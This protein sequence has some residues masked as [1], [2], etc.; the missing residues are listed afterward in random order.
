MIEE[1]ERNCDLRNLMKDKNAVKNQWKKVW[2]NR[3]EESERDS[4][5]KKL[6]KVEKTEE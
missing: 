2:M 4:D 3:S 1:S 6:V 5:V